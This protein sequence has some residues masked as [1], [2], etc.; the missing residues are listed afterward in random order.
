M[1]KSETMQVDP[2]HAGIR[3]RQ[4][5]TIRISIRPHEAQHHNQE[6]N[7]DNLSPHDMPKQKE[8][9]IERIERPTDQTLAC[10]QHTHLTIEPLH[11][12]A[13]LPKNRSREQMYVYVCRRM[14]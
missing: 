11:P 13:L 14:S 2:C 4:N 8:L 3:A 1:S 9:G 10:T 12:T 5:S 7:H 6:Q